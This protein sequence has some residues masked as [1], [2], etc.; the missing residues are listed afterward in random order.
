MT[1]SSTDLRCLHCGAAVSSTDLADSW[2]SECGKRL[3]SSLRD[4]VPSRERQASPRVMEDE[5]LGRQRLVCGGVI[6]A[7]VG[8][9]ALAFLPNLF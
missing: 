5:S 1:P 2:C 7:L 4:A 3:P 6:V 8:L 9:L